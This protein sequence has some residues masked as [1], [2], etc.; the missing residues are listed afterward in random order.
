MKSIRMWMA[1]VVA[2]LCLVNGIAEAQDKSGFGVNVGVGISQV[3]DRDGS[4]SF[5]ANDIG[6]I[7]GGEYRFNENFAIGFNVFGLGSPEDEF[8]SVNTTIEVRGADLVLRFILPVADGVELFGLAGTAAYK[9]DLEPGGT[10]GLFG[11][12]AVELGLGADLGSGE[13]FAFRLAGRY[14]DGPRDES[15]A[16]ITIGFNYRF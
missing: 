12:D 11:E 8:N 2:M 4:E 1:V 13:N 6:Y 16:L 14:F 7:M 10:N 5:N 9:A 15:G 3:K